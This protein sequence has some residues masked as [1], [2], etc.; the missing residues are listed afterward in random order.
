MKKNLLKKLIILGLSFC[1][2][3]NLPMG[4]FAFEGK[5]P[6]LVQNSQHKPGITY[7]FTDCNDVTYYVTGLKSEELNEN[8][9]SF[10]FLN[11][12]RTSGA[13]DSNVR[14]YNLDCNIKIMLAV[15]ALYIL[16]CNMSEIF[17]F[18]SSIGKTPDVSNFC[19]KVNVELIKRFHHKRVETAFE[20]FSAITAEVE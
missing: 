5:N 16:D 9:F 3:L 4:V 20:M 11:K 13:S 18:I 8:D 7:F 2:S 12:T 6:E 14:I 19:Y 17:N 10:E 1:I 15:A